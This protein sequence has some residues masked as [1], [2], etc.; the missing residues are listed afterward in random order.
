MT[1]ILFWPTL[2][3]W[4]LWIDPLFSLPPCGATPIFPAKSRCPV[5]P[6]WMTNSKRNCHP[7]H[8]CDVLLVKSWCLLFEPQFF[9]HVWWL[10]NY[11][12][13]SRLDSRVWPQKPSFQKNSPY[14]HVFGAV[15]PT[16]SHSA[17]LFCWWKLQLSISNTFEAVHVSCSYIYSFFVDL[18]QTYRYHVCVYTSGGQRWEVMF[19]RVPGAFLGLQALFSKV[20]VASVTELWLPLDLP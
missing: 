9:V 20:V 8:S 17:T 5:C 11:R 16:C 15:N 6:A 2:A 13:L 19:C 1:S 10:T 18:L 3:T 7:S 4:H 12:N 14:V